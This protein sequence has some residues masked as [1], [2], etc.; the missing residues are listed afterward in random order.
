M[1]IALTSNTK[2]GAK[3]EERQTP[4]KDDKPKDAEN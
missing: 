1:D 2:V 4:Y 3:D